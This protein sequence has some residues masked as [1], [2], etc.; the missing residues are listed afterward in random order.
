MTTQMHVPIGRPAVGAE[1]ADAVANV[2]RS[3]M[4]T[5]GKEVLAAEARFAEVAGA[6]YGIA[7]SNGTVALELALAAHRIGA[8]DEVI[9]TPFSFF[10]TASSIIRV[11]ATPVFVDI[12]PRS[13]CVT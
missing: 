7:V 11:G 5:Q 6:K 10:A 13:Y 1:E 9:T 3:G 4:L 12:D 2:I 8:G